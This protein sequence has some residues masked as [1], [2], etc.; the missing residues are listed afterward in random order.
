MIIGLPKETAPGEHRVAL[1]PDAVAKLVKAGHELLVEEG[2]GLG[3]SLPDAAY[4]AVGARVVEAGE[5]YSRATI[6]V[7]VTGPMLDLRTGIDEVALLHPEMLLIGFLSPLGNPEYVQRLAASGVT[8]LAMEAI[9]RISRA[10][11]M[12]ALSSQSSIAGYKAILLAANAL[13]KF[14]PMLTTAAGTIPPARVL[15]IGAGVAGLQAIA[16]ARRLGAVVQAYDTRAAVGEQ[17]RSLGAK[18]LELDLSERG[19]GEGGYARELSAE[20]ITKQRDWLAKHA[21]THDVVI[22]TALVPGRPAPLLLT[23]E[24]VS[25]MAAGSVIV[26]LAAEAGGNCALTES[27]ESVVK[28]GVTLIGLTN[29][30]ALIPLDASRLYA[31]NVLSLLEHVLRDGAPHLD[32]D[33]EITRGA[34]ICTAGRVT[35][36]PTLALLE[37]VS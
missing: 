34:C 3:A 4:A 13:P 17:V 28:E 37:T 12:D 9:P 2:A 8:A 16:T 30:P 23:A 6:M 11:A 24:A 29:L 36:A 27:G 33:D 32:L 19:E 26:D 20:A 1:V 14:F 22:T 21:A 25:G 15:V 5:L 18:F 7:K 31:R 35:H 10:Q